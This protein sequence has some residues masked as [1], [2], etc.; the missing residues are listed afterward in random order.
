[1][2]YARNLKGQRLG[3]ARNKPTDILS[4]YLAS[5]DRALK[6]AARR[7][8]EVAR[9]T[10]TPLVILK[11]GRVVKVRVSASGKKSSRSRG[12]AA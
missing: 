11:N 5:A 6:R 4:P 8:R 10:G 9:A 3:K 7:A 12:L 2:N 1:M